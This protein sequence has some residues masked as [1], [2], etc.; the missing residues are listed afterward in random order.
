MHRNVDDIEKEYVLDMNGIRTIK[1]RQL[2][3]SIFTFFLLMSVKELD[4]DS[5]WFF[6]YLIWDFLGEG[7]W[8]MGAFVKCVMYSCS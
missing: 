3:C 2:C 6:F 8:G 5:G 1:M 4:C 7:G